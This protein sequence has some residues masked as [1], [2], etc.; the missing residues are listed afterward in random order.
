MPSLTDKAA[1]F[2]RTETEEGTVGRLKPT[3]EQAKAPVSQAVDVVAQTLFKADATI[4]GLSFSWDEAG[5]N[6]R[7]CYRLMAKAALRAMTEWQSVETAPKGRGPD[8]KMQMV[9]LAAPYPTSP[10]VWSDIRQCWWDEGEECWARWP[11]PFPPTVWMPSPI[12][13]EPRS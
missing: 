7:F 1:S 5:D 6:R 11:H 9:L 4:N 10:T 12:L 2:A 13:P 3:R 8:G